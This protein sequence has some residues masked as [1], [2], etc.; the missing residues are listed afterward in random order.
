[1]G[2]C[3][4]VFKVYCKVREIKIIQALRSRHLD[5]EPQERLHPEQTS[6]FSWPSGEILL[7]FGWSNIKRDFKYFP[8]DYRRTHHLAVL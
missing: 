8:M 7:Y 1:M 6:V 2:K 4:L 5:R 3:N